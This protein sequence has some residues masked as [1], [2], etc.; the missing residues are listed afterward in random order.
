MI[1]LIIK[2]FVAVIL[3]CLYVNSI[4]NWFIVLSYYFGTD[5]N[6]NCR[7]SRYNNFIEHIKDVY[8]SKDNSIFHNIAS[9]IIFFFMFTLPIMIPIIIINISS[10]INWLKVG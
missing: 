5:H 10:I 8:F 9:S 2:N 3:S 6:G 1:I 4:A 7:C